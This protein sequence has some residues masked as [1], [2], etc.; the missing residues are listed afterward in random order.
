[1]REQLGV[2]REDGRLRAAVGGEA[3]GIV[4]GVEESV[5]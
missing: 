3:E 5:L 4:A 1:M 2:G